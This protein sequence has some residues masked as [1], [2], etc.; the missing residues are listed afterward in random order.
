MSRTLIRNAQVF[1]ATGAA[2]YP[3]DVLIEGNRIR[4]VATDLGTLDAIG[5]D[6][7]DSPFLEQTVIGA[8]SHR[9]VLTRAPVDG[10][11]ESNRGVTRH[12]T[13][14]QRYPRRAR[15]TVQ[16]NEPAI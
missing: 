11:V 6:I 13:A 2:P 10:L 8:R 9:N 7:I 14:A 12:C 16:R 1:D 3:A 4:V 5:A 15:L